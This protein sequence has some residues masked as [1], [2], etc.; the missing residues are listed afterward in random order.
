MNQPDNDGTYDEKL[1]AIIAIAGLA[2]LVMFMLTPVLRPYYALLM[3]AT[4]TVAAGMAWALLRAGRPLSDPQWP[5]PGEEW[6]DQDQGCH[7]PPG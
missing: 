7:S 3:P 6:E 4:I 5:A 2:L 1:L